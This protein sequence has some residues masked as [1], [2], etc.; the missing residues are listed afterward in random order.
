MCIIALYIAYLHTYIRTY[1]VY[2]NTYMHKLS[3][4]AIS[5]RRY[6]K[7]EWFQENMYIC[8]NIIIN[9]SYGNVNI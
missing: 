7:I 5:T 1:A 9:T 3:G 8:M 6:T 2:V 4:E